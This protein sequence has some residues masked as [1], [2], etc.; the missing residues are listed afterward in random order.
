MAF[1]KPTFHVNFN[2]TFECIEVCVFI[3]FN[4]TSYHTTA[5]ILLYIKGFIGLKQVLM[6][7]SHMLLQ[8]ALQLALLTADSALKLRLLVALE[9]DV[10]TQTLLTA[11]NSLTCFT[12]KLR[13]H[14]ISTRWCPQ[15]YSQLCKFQ[16]RLRL[17]FYIVEVLFTE[18]IFIS[19]IIIFT[20]TETVII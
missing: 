11:I 18:L 14:L 6:A 2:Q 5:I 4:G 12:L 13:Q 7:Q 10:T 1:I 17:Y 15:L 16:M 3:I 8:V 9:S 20:N 19:I